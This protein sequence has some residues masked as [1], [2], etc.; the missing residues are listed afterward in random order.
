[1]FK[2]MFDL[3]GVAYDLRVRDF[4]VFFE[5]SDFRI[6]Q[7]STIV[8]FRFYEFHAKGLLFWAQENNPEIL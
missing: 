5:F 7:D 6:F 3:V 8:Q 1:M 4:H 2:N